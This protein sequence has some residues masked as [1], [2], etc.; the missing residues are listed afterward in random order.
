MHCTMVL[1]MSGRWV[2]SELYFDPFLPGQ[3]LFIE[4]CGTFWNRIIENHFA[5]SL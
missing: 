3:P 4:D 1:S 2:T 5:V